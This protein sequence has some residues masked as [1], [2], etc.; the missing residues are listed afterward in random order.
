MWVF[1]PEPG[2]ERRRPWADRARDRIGDLLAGGRDSDIPTRYET[3]V[4]FGMRE[5]L[6]GGWQLT[7]APEKALDWHGQEPAE[8]LVAAHRTVE[9][10]IEKYGPSEDEEEEVKG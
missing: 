9:Q 5:D 4:D 1:G 8:L 7:V 10:L 3:Y 6:E 2:K